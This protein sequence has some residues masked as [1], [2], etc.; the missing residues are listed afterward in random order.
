[1]KCNST[2]SGTSWRSSAILWARIITLECT[3]LRTSRGFW[4]PTFPAHVSVSP[5][6]DPW[7]PGPAWPWRPSWG[8][9]RPWD[10]R[11]G[12]RIY[13]HVWS[14][15]LELDLGKYKISIKYNDFIYGHFANSNSCVTCPL[16]SIPCIL[17]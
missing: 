7:W 2:R 12:A 16:C 1:M 15:L 4:S 3:H 11:P 10:R 14:N 6:F 8:R 9:S 13:Y 17:L 5:A